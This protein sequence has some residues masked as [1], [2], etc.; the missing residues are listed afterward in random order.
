MIITCDFKIVIMPVCSKSVFVVRTKNEFCLY[1]KDEM[2]SA[3]CMKP[4]KSNIIFSTLTPKM[5]TNMK[6]HTTTNDLRV[7]VQQ[8]KKQI[9][10]SRAYTKFNCS[11]VYP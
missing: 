6:Q 1:Y 3:L 7:F 9:Y 8:T 11:Y 2:T 4:C 10:L 5:H